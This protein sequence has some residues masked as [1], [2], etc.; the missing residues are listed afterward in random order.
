MAHKISAA[1]GQPGQGGTLLIGV[2]DGTR[3]IRG[4]LDALREEERLASLITDGIVPRLMPEIEILSYRNRQLLA[5]VVHPSPLRPHHVAKMGPEQGAYVRV[6]STNRRADRE[7]CAEMSREARLEAF[8]EL[9][10]PGHNTEGIDFRVASEFFAVTRRLRRQDLQTLKIVVPH[11][12]R[13]VPIEVENP[14][15]LPFGLTPEDAFQGVSK[16]RNRVLARVFEE[17]HFIEQWGSGLQ[18]MH[19]ACTGMGLRPPALEELGN[20]VRLTLW[21]SRQTPAPSREPD[22]QKVLDALKVR[23][24]LAPAQLAK[25][26]RLTTRAVRTRMNKL[27]ALGLVRAVGTSSRDP[28]KTY[29]LT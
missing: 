2:E 6:G 21:R 10:L 26:L 23:G 4:V 17:L 25:V 9:P 5:V 19:D 11:Q 12:G 27:A 28:K 15:L 7:L 8:D 22:D 24:A 18:R 29:V 1:L 13:L 20:R 16:V 3:R 14:G